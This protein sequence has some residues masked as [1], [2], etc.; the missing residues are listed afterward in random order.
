[1]FGRLIGFWAAEI[2]SSNCSNCR[3]ASPDHFLVSANGRDKVPARPEFAV[4]KIPHL[5]FDILRDPDRTLPLHVSDDLRH[6][7]FGRYRYQH[8]NMIRHQMSFLDP[9][10][11]PSC[12]IVKHLA[13]MPFYFA[14]K[15]LL[16]ILRRK[17]D[18]VLGRVGPGNFAPSRSQI[19]DVTLSR[20]PARATERRLPPSVGT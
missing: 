8:V 1:M 9:A 3:S 11:L 6:R 14:E 18:V 7:I 20:H 17:H 15:Q 19:P 4:W 12:Q 10:L 5:A 16:A 13:Q 2:F